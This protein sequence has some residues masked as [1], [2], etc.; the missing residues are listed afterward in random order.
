MDREPTNSP[1]FHLFT[2]SPIVLSDHRREP[3]GLEVHSPPQQ[4]ARFENRGRAIWGGLSLAYPCAKAR[5]HTCAHTHVPTH[6][7][8]APSRN[9]AL[10]SMTCI[11]GL[12]NR[13]P[14]LS[15]CVLPPSWERGY[16][17]PGPHIPLGGW[18]EPWGDKRTRRLCGD[19]AAG[20]SPLLPAL[21]SP[22]YSPPPQCLHPKEAPQGVKRRGLTMPSAPVPLS[23][24]LP[25]WSPGWGW[26]D[27]QAS[28]GT[29]PWRVLR[30]ICPPI[31]GNRQHG[32]LRLASWPR[33]QAALA[34]SSPPPGPS[35]PL[36]SAT[37]MAGL[38]WPLS[39]PHT[40]PPAH[41][42]LRGRPY[43]LTQP[44]GP[45]S[46]CLPAPTHSRSL[47]HLPALVQ[48]MGSVMFIYIRRRR[49]EA[50]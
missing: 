35:P 22:L 17:H 13:S 48:A 39:C 36:R 2:C 20:E 46:P 23:P 6:L 31:V 5:T 41:A 25:R 28:A 38:S 19:T 18:S 16:G 7:S 42:C 37:G 45:R 15:N 49:L 32:Y 12:T 26:A 44:R 21:P 47:P 14:E 9:L 24:S 8:T 10:T 11:L 34:A 50:A 43:R 30:V 1:P 29:L 27:P 33:H 40:L 4:S 3:Q